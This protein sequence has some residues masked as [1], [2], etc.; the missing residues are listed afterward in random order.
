[1]Y[2]NNETM[3][4][5]NDWYKDVDLK[6]RH[7]EEVKKKLIK[8]SKQ[9][10][11][12]TIRN[13]SAKHDIKQ[14][15]SIYDCN[16]NVVD[17]YKKTSKILFNYVK[18]NRKVSL[19]KPFLPQNSVCLE[20]SDDNEAELFSVEEVDDIKES[21][22]NSLNYEELNQKLVCLLDMLRLLR[23]KITIDKSG[24]GCQSRLDDYIRVAKELAHE[25][26]ILCGLVW[27][28]G[29]H[30]Y[31][32]NLIRT[33]QKSRRVYCVQALDYI[34]LYVTLYSKQMI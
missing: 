4:S 10:L 5:I 26:D 28:E 29:L 27:T 20:E 32:T 14:I 33:N 17:F 6:L 34:I 24:N 7:E 11:A 30:H 25:A 22:Q 9:A 12:H 19:P 18:G 2:N 16:D 1:M 15:F 3:Q 8:E 13:S 31:I 21:A 23:T